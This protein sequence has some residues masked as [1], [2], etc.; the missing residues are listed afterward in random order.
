MSAPAQQVTRRPFSE[1]TIVTAAGDGRFTAEI[2]ERFAVGD[3][4]HGGL[5]MVLLAKAALARLAAETGTALDPVA[6][7]TEFLR[8]PGLG[9]VEISTEV[10][11]LGRTAS[12]A[13]VRMTQGDKLM[14]TATVT[15]GR[16]PT[17]E[18]RWSDLPDIAAEPPAEALDRTANRL[19]PATGLAASTDVR[20]DGETI[21]FVRREQGPPIIRGWT[22][23]IGE[24][25]DVLYALLA[26][27]ILPPTLFNLGDPGWAPTVQL[28]A[29]L[30]AHPAPGWLRMESRSTSVRGTWFDEDVTVVD[31]AGRL[32][33]QARQIALAPLPRP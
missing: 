21:P 25:P 33:C 2:G 19:A 20:Y 9:P 16:L 4:A 5:L 1:S 14:L 32:V 22:R 17:D 28:T 8:A 7:S 6:I 10:L 11:K 31:S 3:K 30:R 18:P 24:E 29:L 23:P 13:A 26:G 27:D 15:A 12:V